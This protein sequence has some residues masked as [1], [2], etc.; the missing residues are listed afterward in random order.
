MW[1]DFQLKWNPSEFGGI[2]SIRMPIQN[3]WYPDISVYN[4]FVLPQV[5]F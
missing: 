2:A 5:M 4:R 3:L 1:E